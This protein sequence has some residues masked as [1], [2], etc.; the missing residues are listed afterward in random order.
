MR[1]LREAGLRIGIEDFVGAQ[2]ALQ[3]GLAGETAEE[4]RELLRMLWLTST[5]DY[6]LFDHHFDRYLLATPGKD[7]IFEH[8]LKGLADFNMELIERGMEEIEKGAEKEEEEPEAPA[9]PAEADPSKVQEDA[10]IQLWEGK[11]KHGEPSG[12]LIRQHDPIRP[13]ELRRHWQMLKVEG[14]VY[15]RLELDLEPT[16]R[17]IARKGY[18]DGPVLRP[19]TFRT[20][21]LVVLLDRGGS[22]APMQEFCDRWLETILRNVSFRQQAMAYFHDCPT[23]DIYLDAHLIESKPLGHFLKAFPPQQSIVLLVTDAGAGRQS[24]DSRRIMRS[25]RL[26]WRLRREGY[27]QLWLNPMGKAYWE[28]N[29]AAKIAAL[30]PLMLSMDGAGTRRTIQYLNQIL[31]QLE[32]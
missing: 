30:V 14:K 6:P 13:L 1:D 12:R 25:Q 3:Y 28:G 15:S 21:N 9:V 18:F 11:S 7:G 29:S 4:L 2:E 8:V 31:R 17:N 5:E 10:S 32:A 26:S 24:W 23:E 19:R 22:M 16:I 27:R 20:L